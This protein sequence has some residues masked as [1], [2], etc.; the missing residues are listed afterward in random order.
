[1]Q[2]VYTIINRL[3]Y[4]LYKNLKEKLL[5]TQLVDEIFFLF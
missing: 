1:M 2:Q 3:E 5:Q 4:C